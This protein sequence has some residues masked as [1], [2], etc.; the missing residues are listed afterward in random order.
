LPGKKRRRK[1]KDLRSSGDSNVIDIRQERLSRDQKRKEAAAAAV[2]AKKKR[3]KGSLTTNKLVGITVGIFLILIL[4][5]SLN[6]IVDL[7]QKEHV[8][9]E[10]VAALRAQKTEMEK[11]ADE[12]DSDEYIEQQARTWLKMARKGDMIYIMDGDPLLQDS[13]I[14]QEQEEAD[15]KSRQRDSDRNL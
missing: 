13:G 14:T 11:T 9:Q 2:S 6:N 5:S 8:A 7:K 10:E 3:K 4:L 12:A 15:A 1:K